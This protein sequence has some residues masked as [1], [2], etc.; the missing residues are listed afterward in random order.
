MIVSSNAKLVSERMVFLNILNHHF[1]LILP[2]FDIRKQQS[3]FN[4]RVHKRNISDRIS[5]RRT[6]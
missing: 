3:S 6:N 4:Y 1:K 2:V 5:I